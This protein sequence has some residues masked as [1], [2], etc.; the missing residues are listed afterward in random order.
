MAFKM[1]GWQA[2]SS[3]PFKDPKGKFFTNLKDK[4]MGGVRDLW[5]D[6][7]DKSINMSNATGMGSDWVD[8]Q[9]ANDARINA[10]RQ[11]YIDA[12]KAQREK[13]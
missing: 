5:Q 1:K 2:H 6:I 3:S 8:S 7:K 9:R 12:L 13:K 11:K 4:F 10:E